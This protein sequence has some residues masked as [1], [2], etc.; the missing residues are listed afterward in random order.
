VVVRDVK[1]SLIARGGQHLLLSGPPPQRHSLLTRS[2]FYFHVQ[3]HPPVLLLLFIVVAALV[4]DLYLAKC[5]CVVIPIK[6]GGRYCSILY[7]FLPWF[8]EHIL[9]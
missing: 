5:V 9:W 4:G 1:P 6:V 3:H 2:F 7:L 8:D